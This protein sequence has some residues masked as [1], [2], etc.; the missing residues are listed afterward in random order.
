MTDPTTSCSTPSPPALRVV[1]LGRLLTVGMPQSPNHP[2]YWHAHPRR[3]GDMVRADGG[4]AA[5]DMITMGTHVGTHVDALSH[6]SQDGT[7]ACTTE[8]QGDES[9]SASTRSSRWC[10]AA[11]C[12]TCPRRSASSGSRPARRSPSPTSRRP[13]SGRA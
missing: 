2:A 1:D 6:V 5:N 7:A 3:H 10:A 8:A 9:S 13:S 12:S 4:S 11:C